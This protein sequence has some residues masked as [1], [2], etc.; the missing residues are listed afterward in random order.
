MIINNPNIRPP[1]IADLL[2]TPSIMSNSTINHINK[3]LIG[4]NISVCI[5]DESVAAPR[6]RHNWSYQRSV[7][8]RVFDV[9]AV[10]PKK[11]A[12]AG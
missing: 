8:A 9:L 3:Q 12:E 10:E 6:S 1:I 7:D 2:I 5:E 11:N 4:L